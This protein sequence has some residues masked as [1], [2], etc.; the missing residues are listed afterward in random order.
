LEGLFRHGYDAFDE[1]E[2][3]PDLGFSDSALVER[4]E[5]LWK[6]LSKSE[7][8]KYIKAN[9]TSGPL[10]EYATPPLKSLRAKFNKRAQA[11]VEKALGKE[12]VIRSP[13]KGKE[14]TKKGSS[15]KNQKSVSE[16]KKKV[17]KKPSGKRKR[18][19]SETPSKRKREKK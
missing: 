19:E 7:K 12:I 9:T 15:S 10:S 4:L 14:E 18:E 17:E 3:D 2:S 5:L 1:I 13:P 6:Q 11:L 8:E 16:K